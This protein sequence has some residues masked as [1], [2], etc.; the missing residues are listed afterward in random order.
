M[1]V[2]AIRHNLAIATDC[3]SPPERCCGVAEVHVSV[4]VSDHM[5]IIR[6]FEL[7]DHAFRRDKVV[8]VARA[9]RYARFTDA[10]RRKAVAPGRV[11][12]MLR[13]LVDPV[14]LAA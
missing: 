2:V 4:R 3:E 9:Q 5:A 12:L 7:I 1:V 11:V 13:T 14:D 10:H 8:G 6:H